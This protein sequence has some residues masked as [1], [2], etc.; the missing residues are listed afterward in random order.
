MPDASQ[1]P[2]APDVAPSGGDAEDGV[3]RLARLQAR[4]AELEHEVARLNAILLQAR[5]IIVTTGVDG[6]IT[7]LNEEACLVLGYTS[8]E[9]VGQPAEMLYAHKRTREQLLEELEVTPEGV[10]RAD[11]QVKTKR[12]RKRWLGLSLSWLTDPA[13]ERIGTVGVAKEITA[14]RELEETLRRMSITDKLTGLY[15]QS[16]F[17]HRLEIEKERSRRLGH[18]LALLLF[19]LDGFKGLNDTLGHRVGDEVLRR[20][21]TILFKNVRK[22]VDSAF[23]YG[24]DE[25]TVLLPGTSLTMAATFAERVRK[26]ISSLAVAGYAGKLGASMGITAFDREDRSQQIVEQADKSM[27]LAKRAGGQWVAIFERETGEP[28]LLGDDAPDVTAD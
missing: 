21:G 6:R 19:D 8:E 9:V 23:R 5:D 25:F 7:A 24:G 28:V 11:V 12:G 16:H 10:I 1:P 18:D 20:I 3:D 4:V 14:R 15:N 22:E 17:F 26:Q 13:G 2:L 27:Y